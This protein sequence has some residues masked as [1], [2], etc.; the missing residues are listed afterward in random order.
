MLDYWRHQ[1]PRM[2]RR[3]FLLKADNV[4]TDGIAEIENLERAWLACRGAVDRAASTAA[5][6]F[7]LVEINAP[8]NM[9]EKTQ[10]SEAWVRARGFALPSDMHLGE[11]IIGQMWRELHSSQRRLNIED[12]VFAPKT[13]ACGI[14]SKL[15]NP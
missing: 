1:M 10:I 13:K 9:L 3:H 2:R 7:Q 8:L 6:R 14:A 5:G 15:A 11:N 12:S 4:P